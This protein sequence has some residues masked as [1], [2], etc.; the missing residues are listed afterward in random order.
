MA[1]MAANSF[2]IVRPAALDGLQGAALSAALAAAPMA[3]ILLECSGLASTM[4]DRLAALI[5][6]GQAAGAAVLLNDIP[7]AKAM[8]A[9]GV[10]LDYQDDPD[11]A[12]AAYETARDVLGKDCVVGVNAGLSR[13]HA[14]VLGEAGADYVALASTDPIRQCEL[15]QWWAELFEPP[16]VAWDVNDA[17]QCQRLVAAQADFIAAAVSDATELL[18]TSRDLVQW[19]REGQ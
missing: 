7:I 10:H 4:A 15:V 14:M 17:A 9:D 2:L 8:R 16:V 11:Q 3:S 12:L 5:A 18:N 19:L 1:A 13:H 6:A